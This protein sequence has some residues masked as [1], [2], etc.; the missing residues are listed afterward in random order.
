VGELAR[1]RAVR[2]PPSPQPIEYP[3]PIPIFCLYAVATI[4]NTHDWHKLKSRE[5]AITDFRNLFRDFRYSDLVSQFLLIL[6][7]VRPAMWCISSSELQRLVE[8]L[9]HVLANS[10][11]VL[12]LS[13][14]RVYLDK[15]AAFE[16]FT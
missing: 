15:Q 6:S 5:I 8:V 4:T 3:R 1:G 12:E 11:D 2:K 10:H 9:T 14:G 16:S 13:T 7:E